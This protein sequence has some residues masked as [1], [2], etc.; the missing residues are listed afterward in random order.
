MAIR[1]RVTRRHAPAHGP[2]RLPARSGR[3]DYYSRSFARREGDRPGRAFSWCWPG[4]SV[5]PV[6]RAEATQWLN[7]LS[8]VIPTYNEAVNLPQILPQVAGAGSR[9]ECSSSMT[10]RPTAT[11]QIADDG[12]R[13]F[14]AFMCYIARGKWGWVRPTS[15][16]TS[17]RLERR[18]RLRFSRWMPISS[19]I[20]P[21]SRIFSWR[22][23]T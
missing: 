19:T 11:G 18:L 21:T 17:G 2:G 15:P 3:A 13:P 8:L 10:R 22:C 9:L 20:P 7:E 6:V 1:R 14:R 23:N 5:P 4:S 12:A 16:G